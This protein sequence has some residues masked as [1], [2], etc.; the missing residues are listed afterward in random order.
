MG[1]AV[2]TVSKTAKDAGEFAVET[3][4]QTAKFMGETGKGLAKGDPNAFLDAGLMLSTG[5]L[6]AGLTA[7]LEGG[8]RAGEN[9]ARK[10]QEAMANEAAE[11][12]NQAATDL[13]KQQK[14]DEE[15]RRNEAIQAYFR[16]RSKMTGLPLLTSR[17]PMVGPGSI[18]N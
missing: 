17:D 4:E 5:V 8:Q 10:Q 7:V 15:K 2:Q 18:F 1:G 13:Q 16:K 6:P 9:I 12:A 3:T 11:R 14:A